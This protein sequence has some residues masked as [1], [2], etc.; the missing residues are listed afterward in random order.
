[1]ATNQA[2]IRFGYTPSRYGQLHYAECGEGAPVLLLHQTPRSWREYAAVLP[3]LGDRYRVIAMDTLGYGAS[4]RPA[5]RPT[6]ERWAD[7]AEDL[8]NELGLTKLHVVGHHT[9]GIIG[10]E[11]AA[12][13]AGELCGLLL[14]ATGFIG[15]DSRQQSLYQAPVDWVPQHPDGSHLPELWGR[16]RHCY[17]G[18]NEAALTRYVAD[19]LQVIDTVEQGH[20]AVHAYE[21]WRRLPRVTTR[22]LAICGSE[23]S[24]RLPDLDKFAKVL[25]CTTQVVPGMGVAFPE[26]EPAH[27]ADIIADFVGAPSDH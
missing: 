26:E 19:A 4:A 22:T 2:T 16:R 3:L 21:M 14:S 20:A 10:V 18:G 6:V 23:D 8:V 9:G 11:L 24:Y 7:A 12:R 13:C 5:G 1:M 27:F 15:P 25:R 17:R